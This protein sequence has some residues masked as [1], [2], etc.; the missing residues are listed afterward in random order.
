M[1]SSTGAAAGRIL[2]ITSMRHLLRPFPL[3]SAD[4]SPMACWSEAVMP[5]RHLQLV[6]RLHRPSLWRLPSERVMVAG[7][8]N[9]AARSGH[10]G[11][12]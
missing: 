7:S 2:I 11:K 1:E 9:V 8:S 10:G 5:R 12:I 4:K 3:V 6:S